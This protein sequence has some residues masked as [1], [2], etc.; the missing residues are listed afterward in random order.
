V[1]VVRAGTGIAAGSSTGD[2]TITGAHIRRVAEG[3][4]I[5]VTSASGEWVVS[6]TTIQAVDWA[7]IAGSYT[8]G[9]WQV[10]DTTVRN[11]TVGISAIEATGN[12]T[13]SQGLI[14]DVT[15][16]RQYDFWQP[17]LTEGA[18]I[19]AKRTN[20]SWRIAG[21]RILDAERV[22]IIATGAAPAGRLTGDVRLPS[23]SDGPACE[24]NVECGRPGSVQ[25][26]SLPSEPKVPTD[27]PRGTT[28]PA[29]GTTGAVAPET[30]TTAPST[31][32]SR[33]DPSP[34]ATGA[35]YGLGSAI[36]VVGLILYVLFKSR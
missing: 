8:T 9:D 35:L 16:S 7:G 31:T 30:R 22:G 18:A 17:P 13:I 6:D 12:W 26:D 29:S 1:T 5:D 27:P 21:T 15:V 33:P 32:E 24:G 19:D 14:T 3:S 28:S 2:W 4:G 10:V 25:T 20:G 11:A 34:S 23:T 36:P